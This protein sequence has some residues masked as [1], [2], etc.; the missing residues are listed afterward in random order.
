MTHW[1]QSELAELLLKA[2]S[3]YSTI[4]GLTST[5]REAAEII[6]MIHMLLYLNHGDGDTT[7]EEMLRVYT[8]N[9]RANYNAQVEADRG[10]MN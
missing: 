7:V 10:Q 9:F 5:P 3:L 2:N 6:C 4:V 8:K 1:T